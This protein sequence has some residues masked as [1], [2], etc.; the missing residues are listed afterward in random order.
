MRQKMQ[1]APETMA[2]GRYISK[3]QGIQKEGLRLNIF[4]L[5]YELPVVWGIVLL[6]HARFH[7]VEHFQ[8]VFISLKYFRY[9]IM[10]QVST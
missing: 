4:S 8:N 9:I 1:L 7:T 2:T 10:S 5:L 3:E 6:Q